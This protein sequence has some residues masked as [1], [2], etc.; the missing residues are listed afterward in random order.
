M[1][2]EPQKVSELALYTY[3]DTNNLVYLSMVS[4]WEIQIKYQLGK[5]QL[6]VSLPEMIEEQCLHNGIR[7]L[8]I[9]QKHIFEL[10]KLPF[11][12]KDPFDRLLIAQA[13]VEQ[14]PIVTADSLFTQYSVEVVW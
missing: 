2:N 11:F 10:S 5:L 13:M 12:H 14:I 7:I 6:D 9:E 4:L 3:Q 1:K 8:P